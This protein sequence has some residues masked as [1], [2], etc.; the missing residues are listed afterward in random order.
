MLRFRRPPRSFVVFLVA[1]VGIGGASI[2]AIAAWDVA[3]S[4]KPGIHLEHV[5]GAAGATGGK[6]TAIDG[7][8]NLLLAGTDTRTGQGGAFET[9]DELAGSSGVGQNDV[10]PYRGSLRAIS[11]TTLPPSSVSCPSTPWT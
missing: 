2:V 6:V 4:V 1:V 8:V 9:K 3:R 11:A 10:T 5:P 7:E